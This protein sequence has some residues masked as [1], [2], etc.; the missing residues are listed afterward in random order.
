MNSKFLQ[1]WI[2][3][4]LSKVAEHFEGYSVKINDLPQIFTAARGI[5]NVFTSKGVRE[6]S[7]QFPF[8]NSYRD[9]YGQVRK[10]IVRG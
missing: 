10:E 6:R 8:S 4:N 1:G 5:T 7:L 9:G 2:R 3:Q